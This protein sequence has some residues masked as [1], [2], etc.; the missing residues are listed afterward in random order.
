MLRK[1][2]N[3]ESKSVTFSAIILAVGGLISRILGLLRDRLLAGRIGAGQE[4]D[5]YFTAFRIPDFVY[6]ILIAGGI[7][8][9]FLPVFAEYFKKERANELTNYVLNAF[10]VILIII[11][12]VLA[13]FTGPLISLIAP[14]FS[15]SAKA[16]TVLLT[17]IMFLSPIFLGLSSIFSGILHY[18][19]RFLIYSLAPIL[20]NLGIIFGILFLYPLFGTLG[21]GY[22]VILGALLHLLIQIPAVKSTGYFYKPLLNF[23]F[24]G[25]SKMF[26]LMI[27][28][29]LGMAANHI[30]LIIITA[31]ASFLAV[32]SISVFNFANNLHYFPIGIVGFSFAISSFPIFSKF[33]VNGQKKEFFDN[34][35][36]S[37][38]Q[39]IFY[40]LPCAFLMFILRAQIVRLVLGTGQFDWSATRLTAASLGIFSLAIIAGS[41]IPLLTKAFFAMQDTKTPLLISLISVIFNTV[42]SFYFVHLLGFSNIFSRFLINLLKLESL[43]DIQVIALPLSFSLITALQAI[44]LFCFIIKK[45]G[46]FKYQE[47]Y[48]SFFKNFLAIV[49]TI[50]YIYLSLYIL[51]SMVNMQSFLGILI[52]ASLALFIGLVLYIAFAYIFNSKELSLLKSSFIKQFKK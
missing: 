11:C 6:G 42:F 15:A 39:I 33:F 35:S 41:L 48:Y 29:T 23:S 25:L 27:P 2:S 31:I 9:V 16:A 12:A 13:I 17:R 38:R 32:G 22:G 46:N 44:L 34:F 36:S 1:I 47:I 20:Y 10:L 43:R 5:I 7:V 52:Q 40:I 30:N 19:N 50:P 8:S 21:L 51:A 24:P 18:F 26:R 37:I 28:R 45:I 3:S 4:L 14:G 49:L